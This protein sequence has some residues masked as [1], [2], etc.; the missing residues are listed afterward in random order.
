[1][2][3]SS[4]LKRSS[5]QHQTL[6]IVEEKNQTPQAIQSLKFQDKFKVENP[7][8]NL[9]PA[10]RIC[11]QKVPAGHPKRHPSGQ[12]TKDDELVKHMSNLPGY[13][14]RSEEGENLQEKAL[15]FGVL[16]WERLENW[17]HNQKHVSERGSTNASS[18]SR[19]SSLVLSVGPSTF[20]YRDQNENRK[21]HSKQ[22]WSPG[23]NITSSGRADIYQGTKLAQRKVMCPKD[24]G[25]SPNSNL[26][27]RQKLHYTDKPISRS[28]SGT[29]WQKK[30]VDQNMSEMR[31]SS[32]NLRKH[33][34]SF[35]SKKQMS[36]SDAKIDKRVDVAKE[37]D[38]NLTHKHKNS[39][40]KNV[41][42]LLPPKLPPNSSSEGF[43]LSGDRKS[44][45]EEST[46]NFSCHFSGDFSPVK[47]HSVEC[48]SEI[49]HSHPLT[50]REDSK[51][52]DE[53][54]TETFPEHFSGEL[55]PRNIHSAEVLSEIAQYSC[56]L[57][58]REDKKSFDERS[59]ENFPQHFSRELY[60]GKIHSVEVPSEIAHSCP[61]PC[62]EELYRN[63]NI[64]PQTI[65]I[66]QGKGLPSNACHWSPC[67]REKPTMQSEGKSEI[68]PVKSAVIEI[69]KRQDQETPK[70]RNPSPNRR[71]TLGLG[72]MSRSFSF[73]EGSA[74]PQ[75][76][77]TYLTV[78]SGPVISE[79]P[80]CS[81]NSSRDKTNANSRARS[82]P[83]RRLLDPLLKPKAPNLLHSAETVQ[84]L[85]GSFCWPIDFCESLHNDKQEPSTI[86][87]FLQ[88]TMKNGLPLFKFV[89][90]NKSEILAATVKEL[91]SSGKD[92]SSWIYTFYSVHE[93]KKRSGSWI[94]QGSKGH[95]SSY[96]YN[97]VA[98]M[99]V[100]SSHCTESEQDLKN[101][102]IVKEYVLFGV[103]LTQGKEKAPEFIL[104]RELAAIAIKFPTGNLNHGN[105]SIENKD[106]MEEGVKEV[107]PEDRCSSAVGENGDPC[108][109][110]VILPGGVH[111]LP[112][113]G[114]P[115][116]L[117]DRWKFGGS[118]DCGGWDVGCN[119][120]ILTSQDRCWHLRQPDHCNVRNRFDLFGQ[121]LL[122]SLI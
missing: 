122:T 73:K 83:L 19:N 111:G 27:R 36:S 13:L 41:V 72:R 52:F 12:A 94:S 24:F 23:S 99:K 18:T 116:P 113:S 105:D 69:S 104:N 30:D 47:I 62:G 54:S 56:P 66:T 93:I 25:T 89:V 58:C 114:G 5:R 75:L 63:S 112:I 74:P 34:V 39:S 49:R 42:L 45:K 77:S 40:R 31:T 119:L 76:S 91:T 101:Q 15:N 29:L 22:H 108:T 38:Y 67:S 92:D 98:Q 107:F 71:F 84:G 78:R 57:P 82:S 50:C 16:N 115:T 65:N 79:S 3:Y 61:L 110:T 121:V 44:F 21:Q 64:K 11:Q 96:A 103:Y 118:C 95:N 80:A 2:G 55:S 86:Q 70:G 37:S 8:G 9:S 90:N 85:E 51:L 43:Q 20:S 97:V 88:L 106:L 28:Y 53:R 33:R 4:E 60:P 120:Q 68:K 48:P 1:M 32:S 6:K 7:I 87:A 102:H 26:D 14:Q 17:K 117:I 46:E 109:T 35:S 10:G 81:V 100:S 59:T